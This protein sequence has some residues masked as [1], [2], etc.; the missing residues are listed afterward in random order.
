MRIFKK[1]SFELWSLLIFCGVFMMI[2]PW[3]CAHKPA[4]PEVA[5]YTFEYRGERF[6]I[7]SVYSPEGE[8][9]NELIGPAFLARDVDQN[10]ILD[11]IVLGHY[12]LSD[13]QKIY[14]HAL[15][16]LRRE[17][18]LKQIEREERIYQY[19]NSKFIFEIKTEVSSEG[20]YGN[21]FKVLEI[22][23][24]FPNELAMAKDIKAD[25][26]LDEV[27]KGDIPFAALQDMYR[28]CII[29]G[30]EEK[31]LIKENEFIIVKR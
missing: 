18:H 21:T 29:K 5:L 28:K 30:V 3:H 7:R 9:F 12:L 15:D 10:G 11:Q 19:R 14:A 22:A 24:L 2:G 4:G 16:Q 31:K 27:V 26:I 6:R 13:A 23:Q 1:V 8:S 20:I 25:G 17:S